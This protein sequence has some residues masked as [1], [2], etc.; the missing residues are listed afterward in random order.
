MGS[1]TSHEQVRKQPAASKK[2]ILGL[3]A[4][5]ATAV[6]GT[7]SY[8]AATTSSASMSAGY[9]GDTANVD[10]NLSVNGNNNV[11]DIILNLF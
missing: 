6:I 2:F 7:T 11:I 4:L 3:A 9:G 8:A 10:L 5:A 1:T